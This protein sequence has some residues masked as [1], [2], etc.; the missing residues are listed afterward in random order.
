MY[1]IELMGHTWRFVF[2][3]IGVVLFLLSG[4]GFKP[5][6]DRVHLV[7]LGLAAITF[8]TFWDLLSTL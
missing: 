1:A 6:G 3:A 7:G 5:V 4:I 8:P 2:F